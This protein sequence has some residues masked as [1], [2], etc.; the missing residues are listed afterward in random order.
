[1]ITGVIDNN[2]YGDDDNVMIDLEV[3][4][5]ISVIVCSKKITENLLSMG[6]TTL[7]GYSYKICLIHFNGFNS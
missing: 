5:S 2:D 1:M 4:C 3:D 6:N 7:T